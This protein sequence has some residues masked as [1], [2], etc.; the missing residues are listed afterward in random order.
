MSQVTLLQKP[1]LG[2]EVSATGAAG[3]CVNMEEGGQEGCGKLR[4]WEESTECSR[5]S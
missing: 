4:E 1:F 3:I 2:G 5:V